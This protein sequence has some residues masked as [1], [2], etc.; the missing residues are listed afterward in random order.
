LALV[1]SF[2]GGTVVLLSSF[3]HADVPSSLDSDLTMSFAQAQVF[4]G[5][6]GLAPD[7]GY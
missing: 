1:A 5:H 7:F 2:L 4:G 6:F 3:C